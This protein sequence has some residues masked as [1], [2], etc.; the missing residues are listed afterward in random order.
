MNIH[1]VNPFNPGSPVPPG[2]FAGRSQQ[3]NEIASC[4]YQTAM[5]N[6]RNIIITSERGIGKTSIAMVAKAI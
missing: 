1:K 6:S 5:L 4:I 2:I 3:L